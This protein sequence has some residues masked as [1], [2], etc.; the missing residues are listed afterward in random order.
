VI[1]AHEVDLV[2]VV[3]VGGTTQDGKEG[4]A[5]GENNPGLAGLTQEVDAREER[6]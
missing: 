5:W 1:K 2:V 3:V 6:R 4:L